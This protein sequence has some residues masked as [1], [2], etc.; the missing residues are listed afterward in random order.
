MDRHKLRI[1]AGRCLF[2]HTVRAPFKGL[3]RA[4]GV[5][6]FGYD[7]GSLVLPRIFGRLNLTRPKTWRDEK[8][9]DWRS[10]TP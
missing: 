9:A 8:G 5:L 2:R 1:P 10:L 4:V 7:F 3:G 6:R